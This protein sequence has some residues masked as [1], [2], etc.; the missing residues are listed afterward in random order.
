M[1]PESNVLEAEIARRTAQ[2]WQ[3]ISKGVNEAQLRKP[4]QFSFVWAFLWFLVFGVGLIV[5]LLW[6]WAK[7]D[8]LIYLWVADGRLTITGTRTFWGWL[9]LPVAAYWRWAGQRQTGQTKALAYGAP[10]AGLL[11]LVIVIAAGAAAGG[12]GNKEETTAVQP[13]AA[14]E[15]TAVAPV[16]QVQPTLPPQPTAEKIQRIVTATAGAVAEAEDVRVTLNEITDPWVSPAQF[17]P[18]QPDPGMRFVALD[19]TIEHVGK[20]GTHFAC[21]FGFKLTDAE[22]YAYDPALI[23]DL[24]PDLNC[25]D[26]GSGEKTR[27]WIGFEVREGGGLSLLKYDPNVFTTDD[28]EFRFR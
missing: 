5:Y 22:G 11:I 3:V 23:F 24:E 1:A 4:K 2:G 10:V 7:R 17:A 26:L 27:G 21:G 19:V 8:Q 28:I 6:H 9:F 14:A 16:H 13:T 20:G 15:S 25:I 12:G 18:D